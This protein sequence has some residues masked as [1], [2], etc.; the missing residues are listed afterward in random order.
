MIKNLLLL[1]IFLLLVSYSYSQEHDTS[2]RV[3]D[4]MTVKDY[5]NR[6]ER[7]LTKE[8]SLGFVIVKK[9]TFVTIPKNDR[10]KVASVPYV[11][12]DSTF[13]NYYK[14]VA[15]TGSSDSLRENSVM[16]YWK[17][18]IKIFFANHVSKSEKKSILEFTEQISKNVDSLNIYE[19]KTIDD[20]NYLIYY[21]SDF[22]YETKL[23][24]YKDASYW[25]YWNGTNQLYKAYIKINDET[26]FSEQLRLTKIKSLFFQSLGNFLLSKEMSCDSYFSNCQSKDKH[27][28][29]FDF[30]L[31]KYHYTYGICKGTSLHTFEEQHAISKKFLKDDNKLIYFLHED[32]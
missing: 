17:N 22:E 28:T 11:F 7:A 1:P 10:Y 5:K 4:Y 2:N 13:L 9:D 26:Y 21:S 27:I 30:E 18:D 20:S 15:F 24:N 23:A 19:A 12:K 16:K 8:D 31:L 32:H 3:V 29:D 14:K 6:Y 25:L